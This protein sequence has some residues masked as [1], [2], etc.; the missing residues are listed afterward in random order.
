MFSHY[1]RDEKQNKKFK[2]IIS[3]KKTKL[4]I[5]KIFCKKKDNLWK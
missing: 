5:Q 3:I 1:L 2:Y 4:Y